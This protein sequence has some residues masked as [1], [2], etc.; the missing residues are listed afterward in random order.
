MQKKAEGRKGPKGK[1]IERVESFGV[2]Q[3]YRTIESWIL[4]ESHAHNKEPWN[5][6]SF[7]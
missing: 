1:E 2:D 3:N 5:L 6:F 7:L 4:V